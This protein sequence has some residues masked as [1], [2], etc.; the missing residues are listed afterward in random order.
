MFLE[1]N[2][3]IKIKHTYLRFITIT[4]V[5]AVLLLSSVARAESLRIVSLAPSA[6]EWS[7]ALGLSGSLVA[8]TEQ[9]DFP[10][11]VQQLPK[12]GAFMRTSVEQL[13]SKN[14]TDVVAVD[15]FPSILKRQLE[16]KKIRVHI[17]SI[18][19]LSD[20]S[21]QILRLGRAFGASEKAKIW[22]DKFSREFAINQSS[23]QVSTS[24][25]D[26]KPPGRNIFLVVSIQ[27][28]YVATPISWLSELFE[29]AGYRNVLRD[30]SSAAQFKM[31]FDKISLE[32][33]LSAQADEW[34]T[35]SEDVSKSSL[36]QEKLSRLIG[37]RA[38]KANARFSVY[39]ADVFTRPGPRLIEAW[40]RLRERTK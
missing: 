10:P 11:Q 16:S 20:F 28:L 24:Q 37:S 34:V 39:P 36:Q 35:F 7:N 26:A 30:L 40:G 2:K 8:V 17:F 15:G 9:C 13:F 18:K 19:K 29:R 32:A 25:G 4:F 38:P 27:P 31:E 14:P 33:A 1:S 12:V 6:T 22:A 21:P 3:L 5:A 23:F